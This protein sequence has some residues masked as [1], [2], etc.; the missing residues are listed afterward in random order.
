MVQI[1]RV[2][3][4]SIEQLQEAVDLATESSEGVQ[5]LYCRERLDAFQK[6]GVELVFAQEDA[7][8]RYVLLPDRYTG[9]SGSGFSFGSLGYFLPRKPRTWEP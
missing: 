1:L 5:E 6:L 8:L 4:P 7:K 9:P 3:K 2:T